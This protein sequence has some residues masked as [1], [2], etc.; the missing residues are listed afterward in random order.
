VLRNSSNQKTESSRENNLCRE[1]GAGSRSRDERII[2]PS[3]GYYKTET[4]FYLDDLDVEENSRKWKR[5]KRLKDKNEG[6]YASSTRA[7]NN[8]IYCLKYIE[9]VSSRLRLNEVETAEAKMMYRRL[10]GDRFGNIKEKE[11]IDSDTPPTEYLENGRI[12]LI[13]PEKEHVPSAETLDN[14]RRGSYAGALQYHESYET[15]ESRWDLHG[16]ETLRDRVRT[17][18]KRL[19][20]SE[21]QSIAENLQN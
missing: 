7:K 11:W 17:V 21:L 8:R 15:A 18:Q 10:S 3:N 5:F 2:Q 4:T 14:R 12:V 1:H 6:K 20:T 19:K 9:L 13:E 16:F